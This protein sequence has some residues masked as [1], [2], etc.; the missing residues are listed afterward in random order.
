MGFD[1]TGIKVAVLD[2]GADYTH[3]KLG[4]PGN[5][6][7]YEALADDPTVIGEA[8]CPFFPMKSLRWLR[9]HRRLGRHHH[10]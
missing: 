4:G 7:A 9:L 6:D 10:A 3:A 1:G 5:V 2:D 8:N